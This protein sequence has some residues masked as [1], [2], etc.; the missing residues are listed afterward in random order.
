MQ[1]LSLALGAAPALF[2]RR[3]NSSCVASKSHAKMDLPGLCPMGVHFTVLIPPLTVSSGALNR[4]PWLPRQ[5][6]KG[7]DFPKLAKTFLKQGKHFP[8]GRD[9]NPVVSDRFNPSERAHPEK[10]RAALAGSR[11][12]DSPSGW[13][14]SI[15]TS[16]PPE[17]S[18]AVPLSLRC[19]ICLPRIGFLAPITLLYV[20]PSP[21]PGSSRYGQYDRRL[22]I[23]HRK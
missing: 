17:R 5:T 10:S 19:G 7:K 20:T 11:C 16:A 14:P 8:V 4:G 13:P 12:R 1:F 15:S 9:E 22:K 3:Y 23:A 2:R 6:R 21:K 18:R